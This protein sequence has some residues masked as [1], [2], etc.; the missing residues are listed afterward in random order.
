MAY[1]LATST[2][3]GPGTPNAGYI[4]RAESTPNKDILHIWQVR[5]LHQKFYRN[6]H[7]HIHM[8]SIYVYTLM[9][10]SSPFFMGPFWLPHVNSES[11]PLCQPQSPPLKEPHIH[12]GTPV[13]SQGPLECP[14]SACRKCSAPEGAETEDRM[15]ATRSKA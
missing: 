9:I 14:K 10:M 6:S 11:L 5:P 13:L 8:Y 12:K 2:P 7:T 15:V 1:K 3:K 4:P